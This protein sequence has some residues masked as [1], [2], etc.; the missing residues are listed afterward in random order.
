MMGTGAFAVPTFRAL[1]DSRHAVAGLVTQPA[2]AGPAGH[3]LPPSPMRVLAESNI[4]SLAPENV[5]TDSARAELAAWEPDVFVV[6][7]YGQILAAATLEV[8][9][10]GGVNLHGSLLPKYRGAA[11]VNWA[12]YHGESETGV[13]V[14]QMIPRIDAGPC[15]AQAST[16]IDPDENSIELEARLAQLGAPLV[17]ATIEALAAGRVEP[18]P[19]DPGLATAA[20]RLRKSDGLVDWSRPAEAIRN[21]IRAMEPWPRTYTFWRRT[22]VDAMRLILGRARVRAD[23]ASTWQGLQKPIVPGTVLEAK[24]GLLVATGQ[25]V[26]EIES[27]QPAGKRMLG[28]GEFLRG[29]PLKRGDLL[30]K[31]EKE[32]RRQRAEGRKEV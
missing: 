30:G 8:A 17:L 18:L 25:G 11:P 16:P 24:E 3:R 10:L 22:E 21:Q 6:A 5:N 31:D 29:H 28:A 2:R 20:R 32:G 27:L 19:Q 13:S 4:P 23:D 15:L 14:I 1:L 26:L 9:R 12:I 7:D